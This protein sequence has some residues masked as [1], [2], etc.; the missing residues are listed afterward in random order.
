MS[1][2]SPSVRLH[3]GKRKTRRRKRRLTSAPHITARNEEKKKK[4][5]TVGVLQSSCYHPPGLFHSDF[6][7]VVH[8]FQRG[9]GLLV[10]TDWTSQCC[11]LEWHSVMDDLPHA[12]LNC[13]RLFPLVKIHTA[14]DQD[15][16][17]LT[18]SQQRRFFFFLQLCWSSESTSMV[19]IPW[20]PPPPG[21]LYCETLRVRGMSD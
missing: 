21:C 10:H 3:D 19:C 6:P 18:K 17:I 20:A 1:V 16:L 12:D 11:E 2:F 4:I 9:H 15:K 7:S 13:C 14:L 5:V 8:A